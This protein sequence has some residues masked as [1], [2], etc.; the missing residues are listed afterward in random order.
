MPELALSEIPAFAGMTEGEGL[1]MTG[2]E[3]LAMTE[4]NG[5]RIAVTSKV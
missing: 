5:F 1:R 3:G 2:N 4:C